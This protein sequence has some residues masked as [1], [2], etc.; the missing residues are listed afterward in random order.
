MTWFTCYTIL[1][2]YNHIYISIYIIYMFLH[3]RMV[4]LAIWLW[5]F[6]WSLHCIVIENKN[7]DVHDICLVFRL[8]LYMI[9][10]HD[11]FLDLYTWYLDYPGFN[12]LQG[13]SIFWC[14]E[15]YCIYLKTYIHVNHMYVYYLWVELKQGSGS[16]GLIHVV[17]DLFVVSFGSWGYFSMAQSPWPYGQS[18]PSPSKE[19]IVLHQQVGHN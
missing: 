16:F 18:R 4:I 17:L 8:G 15:H 19:P 9:F 6:T 5:D 1:Y 14:W 12:R 7:R 3:E 10:V 11:N 2:I 13:A